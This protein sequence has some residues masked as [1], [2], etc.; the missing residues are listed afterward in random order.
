ML[1]RS[2]LGRLVS[3]ALKKHEVLTHN[4]KELEHSRGTTHRTP[5]GEAHNV[6]HKEGLGQSDVSILG[7]YTHRF[8]YRRNKQIR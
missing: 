1:R 4:L 6:S 2:G 3:M 7:V 5:L 8:S